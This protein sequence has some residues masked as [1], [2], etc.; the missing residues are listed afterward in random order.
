MLDAAYGDFRLDE[1][2][3]QPAQC[4]LS[5]D[6]RTLQIRP[7]VMDL[8]T[9]FV[10][11]QGEVISKDRLLNDVWGS[12]AVSESAL[13]RTVTELRQALRE[14]ACQP[15]LLETIPSAVIV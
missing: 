14:D 10:A 7:R 4:R 8:L 5:K 15:R 2:L 9:Y 1:W 11:H 6:G 12:E 13:T 3:V